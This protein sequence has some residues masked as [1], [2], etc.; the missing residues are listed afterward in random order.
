VER[1]PFEFVCDHCLA[2]HGVLDAEE[3]PE[4]CPACGAI[5]PWA[6]PIVTP[7]GFDLDEA[8]GLAYS[9]LYVAALSP[10]H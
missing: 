5:E 6:G 4:L 1:S 2:S 7:E 8:P 9:P 3:L 10:P